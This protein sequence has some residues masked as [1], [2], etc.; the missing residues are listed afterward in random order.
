MNVRNGVG[1]LT[2]PILAGVIGDVPLQGALLV[3]AGLAAVAVPVPPVLAR[4]APFAGPVVD[5]GPAA[6][7]LTTAAHLA[8]LCGSLTAGIVYRMGIGALIVLATGLAIGGTAVAAF[9]TGPLWLAA[10]F[11]FVSGIGAGLLQ[12][13]GPTLATESA[14]L[15]ERGRS[16]AAVGTCRAA[17]LLLVPRGIGA[18]VLVLPSAALAAAAV[19]VGLPTVLVPPG[20]RA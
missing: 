11:L 6:G 10:A 8:A 20:P 4:P 5:G 9:T 7:A 16:L 14:G 2:G 3:A 17:S 18:L 1:L 15:E 19:V 12:T 13:L